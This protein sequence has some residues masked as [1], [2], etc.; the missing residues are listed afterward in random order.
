MERAGPCKCTVF[1]VQSQAWGKG[2]GG[3]TSIRRANKQVAFFQPE[4]EA[5]ERP[6]GTV[7]IEADDDGR[8]GTYC[9]Q[10]VTVTTTKVWTETHL[11]LL[12]INLFQPVH[13][14]HS[15]HYSTLLVRLLLGLGLL[16]S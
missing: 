3:V 5:G 16:H 4:V 10:I 6:T 9:T 8:W 15:V 14:C 13:P 7:T 1:T 11:V 12:S 2:P